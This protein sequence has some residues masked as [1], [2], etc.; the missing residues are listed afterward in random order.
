MKE[1]CYSCAGKG[2]YSQIHGVH[3]SEDF[4][5][6]GFDE[7]PKIHNYPCKS[8]NGTGFNHSK[9]PKEGQIGREVTK[10]LIEMSNPMQE[11]LETIRKA[12]IAT[13]PAIQSTY[14][15]TT[16]NNLRCSN[17]GEPAV[18]GSKCEK[19]E[20]R[21]IRL[22]DVLLAI[23]KKD[24]FKNIENNF[25]MYSDG[26]MS[27]S[28]ETKDMQGSWNLLKDELCLQST[29]TIEFLYQLFK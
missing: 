14:H 18:M 22:A 16:G 4:G 7:K 12:C 10:G 24:G 9:N 17:C 8:C 1:K 15:K 27:W 20:I 6:D 25:V 11:K 23:D 2:T 3:G 28:S 5:G 21:P 29:E 13:N 19:G 26:S